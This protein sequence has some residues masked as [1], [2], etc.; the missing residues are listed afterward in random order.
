MNVVDHARLTPAQRLDEIADLLARG[1]QRLLAAEGKAL[2]APQISQV[3][4]ALRRP[5][6]AACGS[7][8]LNPKS[9]EP[10]A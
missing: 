2:D 7:H 5:V 9:T 3:R 1:Y 8:A 10:A 6:E 4:L